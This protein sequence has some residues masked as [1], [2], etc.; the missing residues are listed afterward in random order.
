MTTLTR[1]PVL[2]PESEA[3]KGDS[4]LFEA[5]LAGLSRLE[6]TDLLEELVL[7]CA[8]WSGATIGLAWGV[9]GAGSSFHRAAATFSR[10]DP[11]FEAIGKVKPDALKSWLGEGVRT[12]HGLG[13]LERIVPAE[14]GEGLSGL[15]LPVVDRQGEWGGLIWLGFEQA[16]D[17]EVVERL[18]SLL[19]HSRTAVEHAM[20][21]AALR[22]LIIK[23][24]TAACYNRRY[25]DE[26]FP[27]ELSRA[28]RFKSPVSLIFLDM[29]NL[30]EVNTL[31]GHAMGSRTL[32][33]VSK[34]IRRRV[35]KFDKLFRFGGDEFCIVLPETE[36]QGAVEVAER[37][38]DAVNGER[39][40]QDEIGGGGI[41]MTARIGIAAFPLH[42]RTQQGLIALADEAMQRVKK[43]TK[44]AVGVA[45]APAEKN[46][47]G[48]HED[49]EARG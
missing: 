28:G 12:Q 21:V 26:F 49:G 39:F 40:L 35:R 8:R 6:L 36:W 37:V 30:K 13:P 46:D 33:E 25:F 23:D 34:R 9:V 43:S 41:R 24:D 20:Q 16:P 32:M 1:K 14:L 31:H 4:E 7:R 3:L 42:A 19:E 38:R 17:A 10:T 22:R 11:D 29:D 18:T 5:V 2:L 44:D 15:T 45:E 27:E 47:K 48:D